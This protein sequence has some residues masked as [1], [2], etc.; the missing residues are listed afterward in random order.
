MALTEQNLIDFLKDSLNLEEQ[1]EADTE[2]FSTGLLD[3]VAMM[4]MIVFVEEAA[5]T[6]VHPGDVNLENFDTVARIV[7]LVTSQS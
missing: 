6:E 2:L 1:I 5:R 3:S 4:N 7:G